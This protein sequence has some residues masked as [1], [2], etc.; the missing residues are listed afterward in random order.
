MNQQNKKMIIGLVT[1]L[2][3]LIVVAIVIVIGNTVATTDTSVL[4]NQTVDGLTFENGNI[5]CTDICTYTVDVYNENKETYN[6]KTINMNFKQ[7]DDSVVTLVGYIGESLESDEGRK[8]TA[9]ID[10]DISSSVDLEYVI[11]K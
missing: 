6:L 5:E 4:R 9:S 3:V 2:S 7:E 8:I 1:L 10:K 11:N